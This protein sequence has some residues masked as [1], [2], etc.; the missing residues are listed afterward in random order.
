MSGDG[1][2]QHTG[3]MH[4][5][6]GQADGNGSNVHAR[7]LLAGDHEDDKDEQDGEVIVCM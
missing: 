4:D 1:S 6:E 7:R 3:N 2:K 5:K